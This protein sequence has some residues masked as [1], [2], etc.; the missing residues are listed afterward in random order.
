[1]TKSELIAAVREWLSAQ[2]IALESDDEGNF[3]GSMSGRHGLWQLRLICEDQPL[4]L[5][6]ICH[7]PLR[8]PENRLAAAGQLLHLL[9]SRLRLGAYNIGSD[10]EPIFRVTLA[11]NTPEDIALPFA[12]AHSTFDA[13]LLPL[14]RFLASDASADTAAA[15]FGN[16]EPQTN[17]DHSIKL[18]I[19]DRGNRPEM[20]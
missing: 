11:I 18:R 5:H 17:A 6:V 12:I 3:T 1:M 8:L 2:Q 7:H 20:N 15:W 14:A 16:K 19:P 9:N 4:L 13:A 10:N